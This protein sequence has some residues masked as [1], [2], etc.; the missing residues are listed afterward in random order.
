MHDRSRDCPGH[1]PVHLSEWLKETLQDNVFSNEP[2]FQL[3]RTENCY[4][5]TRIGFT[6]SGAFRRL[7]ALRLATG[8]TPMPP[9]ILSP[10]CC[11]DTIGRGV[12]SP[13][14]IHPADAP[15]SSVPARSP[16]AAAGRV[17]TKPAA[18]SYQR[19]GWHHRSSG[20]RPATAPTSS[21]QGFRP[22][23][24]G[25]GGRLGPGPG[26][27]R[28]LPKSLSRTKQRTSLRLQNCCK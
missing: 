12:K 18:R 6:R 14:M 15:S 11:C 21:C 3:F 9:V 28:A 25:S 26:W 8:N 5:K 24:G 7:A 20:K 13:P 23:R 4:K 19:H 17:H 2:P 27:T 10:T 22:S 1:G 16:P